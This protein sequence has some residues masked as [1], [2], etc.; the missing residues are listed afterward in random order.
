MNHRQSGHLPSTVGE[1]SSAI[2]TVSQFDSPAI[3]EQ[4]LT[5]EDPSQLVPLNE[6]DVHVWSLDP[7]QVRLEEADK[8]FK[9]LLCDEE[10]ARCLRF[11]FDRDRHTYLVARSLL[12]KALSCYCPVSPEAWRFRVND[13][14]KPSINP[15]PGGGDI[16][17][18]VTHTRRLAALAIARRRPIGIDAEHIERTIQWQQLA[19]DVLAEPEADF[20]ADLPD[21]QRTRCFFRFWTLKEAYIKGCGKGLSIPLKSFWFDLA[22]ADSPQIRFALAQQSERETWS[23]WQSDRFPSHELAVAVKGTGDVTLTYFSGIELF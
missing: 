18:N 16:C 5:A 10:R 12:R 2:R 19:H 11:V 1:N 21:S 15:P 9:T 13:Y 3:G 23:F 4:E 20:L 14:G 7:E 8:C 17:F 6:Q 22:S